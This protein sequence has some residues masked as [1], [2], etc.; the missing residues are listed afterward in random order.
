MR[1]SK[2]FAGHNIGKHTFVRKDSYGYNGYMMSSPV[3]VSS[4]YFHDCGGEP[5]AKFP[6][7]MARPP[8]FSSDFYYSS[9]ASYE[10]NDDSCS[11]DDY[12][13]HHS[14]HRSYSVSSAGSTSV[15]PSPSSSSSSPSMISDVEAAEWKAVLL[16][17]CGDRAF[18]SANPVAK[19]QQQ[20]SA[21][22]ISEEQKPSSQ[23]ATTAIT[24]N[25]D[26]LPDWET[27]ND[28]TFELEDLACLFDH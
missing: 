25:F 14:R 11:D 19:K 9:E 21:I 28:S 3:S 17:Y 15:S 8:V 2:K 18:I 20:Q 12:N 16:Y 23:P 10:S 7:R 24:L 26:D 4:S 1:I 27:S 22:T 5:L 13:N 6:R